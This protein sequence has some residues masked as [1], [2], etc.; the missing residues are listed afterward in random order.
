MHLLVNFLGRLLAAIALKTSIRA[1]QKRGR[2]ALR[3]TSQPNFFS[4][5]KEADHLPREGSGALQIVFRPGRHFM[6]N[7]FFGSASAERA[8]NA[9]EQ[10][11]PGHQELLARRKLHRI[12]ESGSATQNE[13][14]L[15][16]RIGVFAICR[17]ESMAHFVVRDA[18]LFL[19]A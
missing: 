15:M 2:L 19:V 1:S 3:A 13:A 5:A 10:F 18:P 14:D 8:T 16:H 6:K 4:H 12:S 11:G 7:F 17:N 9:I